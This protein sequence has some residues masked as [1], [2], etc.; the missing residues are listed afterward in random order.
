MGIRDSPDGNSFDIGMRHVGN[1]VT[2]WLNK[3]LVVGIYSR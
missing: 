2:Q 3:D 1:E